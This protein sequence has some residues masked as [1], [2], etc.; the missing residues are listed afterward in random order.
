MTF[1]IGDFVRSFESGVCGYYRLIEPVDENTFEGELILNDE[2]SLAVSRLVDL[3]TAF[4][5]RITRSNLGRYMRRE[6]T[7]VIRKYSALEEYLTEK[8]KVC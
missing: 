3:D 6:M 4:L 1:K 5:E 2:G 7:A 8:E